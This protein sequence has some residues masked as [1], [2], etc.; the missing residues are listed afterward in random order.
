MT[1]I[2]VPDAMDAVYGGQRASLL[3]RDGQERPVDTPL[4]SG[5][6][7]DTDERLFVEPCRGATLDVGCGPGRLTG[8]LARR[9]VAALGTDISRTAVRQARARGARA[10]HRDVFDELPRPQGWRHVLLADGNIGIGGRPV[11]L[12]RRVRQLLHPAGSALVELSPTAS[13]RVHEG[14]R[15]RVGDRVSDPFAWATVGPRDIGSVAAAAGLHVAAVER[16]DGRI[17]ATLCVA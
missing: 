6:P 8:A 15:L 7:T 9:G 12:L 5:E 16:A 11:E 3:L 14:V 2:P 1:D 10:L 4:W 13:Y 17:A